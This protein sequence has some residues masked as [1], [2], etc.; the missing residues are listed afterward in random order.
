[1]YQL[2]QVR[3]RLSLGGVGPK[4]KSQMLARLGHIAMQHEI[5]EQGLQASGVEA[6]YRLIANVQAKI[7]KQPNVQE[8]GH[9]S[10]L[11]LHR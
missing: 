2:A 5:G 1:M 7:A 11:L 6:C 8:R 10:D 9:L 4:E 3:S